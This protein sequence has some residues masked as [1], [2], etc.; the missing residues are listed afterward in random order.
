[1]II[2]LV[3]NHAPPAQQFGTLCIVLLSV[4]LSGAVYF[5]I[6]PIYGVLNL[7]SASWG[8]RG[9]EAHARTST[10]RWKKAFSGTRR[11]RRANV[12]GVA[13][14]PYF[15]GSGHWTEANLKPEGREVPMWVKRTVIVL[16]VCCCN[17][18]F[19]IA[20]VGVPAASLLLNVLRATV[21][22]IALV[23]LLHVLS[24]VSEMWR[25]G[26]VPAPPLPLSDTARD[27]P[28]THTADLKGFQVGSVELFLIT[29][30]HR[31]IILCSARDEQNNTQRR[32]SFESLKLSHNMSR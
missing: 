26:N 6:I 15:V 14:K 8:T 16:L 30:P 18:A 12:D 2:L 3:S 1:M 17:A 10:A 19:V 13:E 24:L 23:F 7:D 31:R 29:V 32:L 11:A 28:D 4:L 27:T 25:R 22:I 5:F 20:A 21:A 9:V